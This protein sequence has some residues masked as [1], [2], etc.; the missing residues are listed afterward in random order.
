ML[1]AN[2]LL[3][4]TALTIGCA[5]A[6]PAMTN[7][8]EVHELEYDRMYEAAA[9]VLREEGFIVN[10][11]DYRFGTISARPAGSPTVLEPWKKD[12]SNFDQ[13]LQSTLQQERRQVTIRFERIEPPDPTEGLDL[14][15]EV[16]VTEPTPP[17]RYRMHAEVMIEHMA[18]PI[19]RINGST[20]S[21]SMIDRLSSV[22]TEW[23][24]RGIPA[25]E[26]YPVER[27]EP[28]EL[29]LLAAI[30]RH[31]VNLRLTPPQTPLASQQQ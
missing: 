31:A 3:I 4:L 8:V 18:T 10:Q 23:R 29:R 21:R 25:T 14:P 12:H 1:R 16:V 13:A 2:L 28:M 22:P 20:Q 15:P 26:W 24:E 7:P 17:T 19:T 5:S 6:T 11:R 30:V 27:D 9:I